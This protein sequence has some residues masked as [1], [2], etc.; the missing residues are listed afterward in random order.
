M[1]ILILGA[2]GQLGALLVAGAPAHVLVFA[3]SSSDIN[4]CNAE[5]LS[6]KI[7]ALAPDVIINAAAYT[8]VDKA[9]AEPAMAWAVNHQGVRNIIE[10][11]SAA[12]R[13]IHISTDFVFD[14]TASTP[15]LPDAKVNPLSVYG[16]SKQA[17]E[18]ELLDKAAGRSCIIRTAWLYAATGKNFVNTMLALLAS[19]EQLNVVNDQKGTP[20]SAH[21]LAEVI[22]RF[23]ECPTLHGIFHWTDIGETTWYSFASEIQ[24]LGLE[25]GLLHK[26]IPIMPIPTSAYPTPARRPAYS[27]LDKQK[28]W[29]A[30]GIKG[31][32]WQHELGKV[33]K[34][35]TAQQD[36]S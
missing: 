24:R 23:V 13:I 17:G 6:Q 2:G 22:W 19:R 25:Y 12:T 31:S 21:T 33:L 9:E 29:S 20:T 4:I 28:T 18:Q 27:V 36:K 3:A 32:P 16:L 1:K 34:I 7:A 35:K 8:Q 5:Q 15:Y 14:G 30:L 26:L 10:A 11:S